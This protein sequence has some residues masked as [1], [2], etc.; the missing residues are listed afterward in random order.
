VKNDFF[1]FFV[2]SRE[3]ALGEEFFAES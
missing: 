1:K 3:N 2:E